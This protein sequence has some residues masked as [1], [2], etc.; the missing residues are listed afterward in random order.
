MSRYQAVPPAYT[1]FVGLQLRKFLTAPDPPSIQTDF[2]GQ[3][4]GDG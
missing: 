4:D 3:S 1:Q 2:A